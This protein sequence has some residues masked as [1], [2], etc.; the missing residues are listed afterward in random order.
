LNSCNNNDDRLE[1]YRVNDP[2][3]SF[4]KYYFTYDTKF[5]I[6][7][8]TTK[9]IDSLSVKDTV[10]IGVT[11]FNR[12]DGKPCPVNGSELNILIE[13]AS[14]DQEFFRLD[15]QINL[16]YPDNV[17]GYTKILPIKYSS[18]QYPSNGML[19]INPNGDKISAEYHSWWNGHLV[20]DTL[21]FQP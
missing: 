13:T 11:E 2:I 15:S 7:L 5:N 6:Y 1:G 20:T 17:T 19:E 18:E 12:S 9:G 8:Y 4:N 16:W 10:F 3:I 21:Y 14:G